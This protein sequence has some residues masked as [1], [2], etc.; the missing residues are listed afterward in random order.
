MT[1]TELIAAL[2]S[3]KGPDRRLDCLI[4]NFFGRARFERTGGFGDFD[5]VR[6]EPYKLTASID[7]AVA[8]IE[9]VR[10]DA[11]HWSISKYSNGATAQLTVPGQYNGRKT[12][13]TYDSDNFEDANFSA[14]LAIALC[15][16]L[17]ESMENK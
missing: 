12:I 3:A 1:R 9:S 15:I 7:A 10:P 5:E 16:A 6:V 14:T 13:I 2:K 11:R 8:L 17:L 4:E